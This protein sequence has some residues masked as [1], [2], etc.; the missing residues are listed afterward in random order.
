MTAILGELEVIHSRWAML[1]ALGCTFPE[2]LSKNG[3]KLGEA[4]WFKVQ[5]LLLFQFNILLFI[6]FSTLLLCVDLRYPIC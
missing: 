3:V 6:V 4:V 2:I 1:G 5:S